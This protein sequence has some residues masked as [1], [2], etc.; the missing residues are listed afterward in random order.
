MH[1]SLMFVMYTVSTVVFAVYTV[2][3]AID[4]NNN[5]IP[6]YIFAVVADT[7]KDL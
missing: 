3:T 1:E 4:R 2:Y 5:M 6:L 7:Y